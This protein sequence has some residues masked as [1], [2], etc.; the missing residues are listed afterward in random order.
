MTP[1]LRI[2]LRATPFTLAMLL[3]SSPAAA[4]EDFDDRFYVAP[5]FSYVLADD[6][7]HTDDGIGGAIAI[8]KRFTPHWELELRGQYLQY[9]G[10]GVQSGLLCGL[11]GTC[12]AYPDQEIYAGG[13]GANLYLSPNGAG[14]YLHGDAMAGDAT[15][16][17]IGAG[18]D[19]GNA[20]GGVSLRVEALYHIDDDAGVEETQFN[21]GFRIPFGQR[22]VAVAEPVPVVAVVP[23]MEPPP[24]PP[25]PP[26]DLTFEGC[27]EGDSF[28]LRGV[29]FE[30]DQARLTV[31][32][33]A[34]LDPV[35]EAL[36]ARPHLQIEIQGHTDDRG[37][38]RYNQKLSEQ[39]AQAVVEYLVLKSITAS[40]LSARGFGESV[41]IA[42]NATDE[43]RELNRRVELKV[44]GTQAA[45]AP[46]PFAA[47]VETPIVEA[48]APDAP[49]AD[50]VEAAPDA[51]PVAAPPAEGTAAVRIGFMVFEPATLR[52]TPGTTVTWTNN[53]GSNHNV[54]FPD[55]K[56]G[57]LKHD[58]TWSRTFDQPGTYDYYCAIHGPSMSGTVIVE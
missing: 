5:M 46:A 39:R 17:N 43:G 12:P 1:Q 35:A 47:A 30:F 53:D 23:P 32:A 18:F 20:S 45:A 24:P 57:R 7:R 6:A 15:V 52:V 21:L 25:P 4:A 44:V 13:I 3:L 58:A 10:E 38:D 42:D 41:P 11:L 26:C 50:I 51:V 55:Q 49:A 48:P 22:T 8:G 34:L 36:V 40:R 29:N 27:N 33:K 14:L 16:Y 19:F 37:S 54:V 31:N 9:E 28:V 2:A 56:S